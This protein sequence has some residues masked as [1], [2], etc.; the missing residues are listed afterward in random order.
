MIKLQQ[1][2]LNVFLVIFL[3]AV[4]VICLQNLTE[5]VTFQLLT[6]KSLQLPL[7]GLLAAV[8]LVSALAMG[9]KQ[10]QW[11]LAL[12]EAVKQSNRQSERNQVALTQAQDHSK[13]LEAKIITLEKAL[14][15]SLQNTPSESASQQSDT[16]HDS[17]SS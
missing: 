14:A 15:K 2:I 7:G 3:S 11:L 10:T 6:W 16:S 13:T 5:P 17:Q 9:A 4:V 12:K 8:A 1:F